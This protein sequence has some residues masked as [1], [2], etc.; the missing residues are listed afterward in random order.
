MAESKLKDAIEKKSKETKDGGEKKTLKS[1]AAKDMPVGKGGKKEGTDDEEL[2]ESGPEEL[3]EETTGG[4]GG[5]KP[6]QMVL[7]NLMILMN[8][9]PDEMKDPQKVAHAIAH[10][11]APILI[12]YKT[13]EA[14]AGSIMQTRQDVGTVAAAHAQAQQQNTNNMVA[15]HNRLSAV[16]QKPKGAQPQRPA[17][18]QQPMPQQPGQPM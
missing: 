17:A 8:L 18:P 13:V 10:L 16:E 12:L 7:E 5:M 6:E 15:L 11:A 2:K 14:M 9:N 1:A 3:K 4:P